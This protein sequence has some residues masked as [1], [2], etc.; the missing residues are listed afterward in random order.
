M[1]FIGKISRLHVSL[2]AVFHEYTTSVAS[3][4]LLAVHA[5][6]L[7]SL[8][9]LSRRARQ[10]NRG[11]CK[12]LAQE[13]GIF[14]F[15]VEYI[16]DDPNKYSLSRLN[17]KLTK[18]ICNTAYG[19]RV[20]QHNYQVLR[21][22]K[23]LQT[24]HMCM[25]KKLFDHRKF[26]YLVTFN[27]G[28]GE[29]GAFVEASKGRIRTICLHK[30]GVMSPNLAASYK[31]LLETRREPFRG[32]LLLVYNNSLK[33]MLI[34]TG[35]YS[36]ASVHVVGAPRFDSIISNIS[37]ADAP[38]RHQLLVFYPS[39]KAQLGSLLGEDVDFQWDLLCDAFEKMVCD[40][41][42]GHPDLPIV[43]KTKQRDMHLIG[44]AL[45]ESSNILI[46]YSQSSIELVKTSSLCLGFNSTA[47][48]ESAAQGLE[49]INCCFGEAARSE[50]RGWIIEFGSLAKSITDP[51]D[52]LRIV[53]EILSQ[54]PR[55]TPL[56]S[57][58]KEDLDRLVGNSDG[59][60]KERIL[61]FFQ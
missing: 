59:K 33:E 38:A 35:D 57:S 26:D 24:R 47:L 50:H 48:I 16:F 49:S 51:R 1:S 12:I 18:F 15:E 40:I 52:G 31:N 29:T 41:A 32:D 3:R 56:T 46:T 27:F 36:D 28:D 19:Q 44:K 8:L 30:E 25:V 11:T 10:A 39:R 45:H 20:D 37:K 21:Q 53:E 13:K 55:R 60:C 43:I 23:F 9:Y 2:P 58:Q 6:R 5:Y 4:L 7:L 22:N 17:R 42:R 54:S 34:E 14:N 61:S